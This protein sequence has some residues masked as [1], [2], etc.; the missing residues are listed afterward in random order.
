[1]DKMLE[2]F[3]K[4]GMDINFS[5]VLSI[6]LFSMFFIGVFAVLLHHKN[7]HRVNYTVMIAGI[8]FLAIRMLLPV[9]FFRISVNIDVHY[10]LPEISGFVHKTVMPE[11]EEEFSRIRV[12]GWIWLIGAAGMLLWTAYKYIFL[13]RMVRSFP[14]MQDE[15]VQRALN[16]LRE[17]MGKKMQFRVVSTEFVDMPMIVGLIKP[18]IIMPQNADVSEEDAYYELRHELAHYY[19]GDLYIKF[20]WELAR[21]ILWWNPLMLILQKQLYGLLEL[22]ADAGAIRSLDKEKQLN[23]AECLVRRTKEQKKMKQPF[24]LAYGGMGNVTVKQR[25]EVLLE[26]MNGQKKGKKLCGLCTIACL[27]AMFLTMNILTLAPERSNEWLAEQGYEGGTDFSPRDSGVFFIETEDG[28]YDLYY[29]YRY[30]CTLDEV[31]DRTMKVYSG[32]EE[33]MAAEGMPQMPDQMPGK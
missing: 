22:R 4:H 25:I 14:V 33:A 13:K 29:D 15:K 27:L 24:V 8:L 19:N 10:I 9:E 12:L 2:M 21:G 20:V 3:V 7:L 6:F 1:M 30:T 5:G 31:F 17:E 16:L 11:G 23:Y 32:L 28:R 18:Y 26:R